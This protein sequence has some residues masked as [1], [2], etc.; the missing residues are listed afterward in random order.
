MGIYFIMAFRN[1]VQ[2]KRRTLLLSAALAFVSLFLVLLLSLSQGITDTMIRSATVLYTGHVNVG[3]WY[4]AKANDAW[5]LVQNAAELR[6]VVDEHAQGVDYVVDRLRGWAKLVSPTSS[7]YASLS[8]IDVAEEAVFLEKIQLAR[9]RDYKE[10]GGDTLAGDIRDLA[11]PNAIV[12]F[13][14]QAKRLGVD[15]GD[16]ITL[17]AETGGGTTNTMDVRV[18]AITKDIG[19]MSNWNAYLNKAAVREMYQLSDKVS[20]AVMV[21]LDDPEQARQVMEDLHGAFVDAGYD[22]MD[23]TPSAFFMKFETIQGEDW[24]GQKVD[25]TTWNDEVG[26]MK[27]AINAIDAISFFLVLIML[28]IIV[29]GIVNTMFIAVRERTNEIGTL[30]ALGMQRR[31]VLR[32]FLLEAAVLGAGASLFGAALGAVVATLL[33]V[34]RIPLGVDALKAILMSD[35]LTLTVQPMQIGLA[36]VVFT[37]VTAIAAFWPAVRAARLLPVTAIH[38]AE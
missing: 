12:L 20:G 15:I 10:D 16:E 17:S 38:H 14:A 5:P 37:V 33:N 36:V 26:M 1:L 18:V 22:V 11:Q 32:V 34:L 2:A 24:L 28:V 7:L 27:W 3:G 9:Q 31:Q 13:A 29:I 4:K 6:K 25:L 21:Y 35:T 30:R 19:F 23:H 8:G